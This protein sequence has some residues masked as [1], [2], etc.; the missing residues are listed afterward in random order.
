MQHD[1][2]LHLARA[3]CAVATAAA[4]APGAWAQQSQNDIDA[5]KQMA[6]RYA[7]DCK[8]P[9]ALHLLVSP[10]SLAIVAGKKRVQAPKPMAAFSFY[11]RSPPKDFDFALLAEGAKGLSL[12]FTTWSPKSG[13]Y[14]KVEA[15]KT[16]ND[17]FGKAAL[18]GKFKR[19]P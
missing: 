11:G 6:G 8:K 16:L 4:L 15:D 19:C 7:V 10:Q 18:A 13:A 1:H 17:Q 9:D 5:L 2:R 12:T 3:L 14:L